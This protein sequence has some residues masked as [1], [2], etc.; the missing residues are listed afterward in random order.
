MIDPTLENPSQIMCSM[1]AGIDNGL[2]AKAKPKATD[3][4]PGI[5]NP[6]C[7]LGEDNYAL[8]G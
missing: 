5:H 6:W 1:W 7:S 2:P 8:T 4:A 3:T